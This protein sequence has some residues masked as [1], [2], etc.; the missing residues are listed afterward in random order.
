[1][2]KKY[3]IY[4]N[5]A[6]ISYSIK[7]IVDAVMYFYTIFSKSDI[8]YDDWYLLLPQIVATFFIVAFYV[9]FFS[10]RFC[11]LFIKIST[12]VIAAINILFVILS[13]FRK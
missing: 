1:M 9:L 4:G 5:F 8:Y 2:K 7:F 6:I 13:F 12:G 10:K 3:N 11:G